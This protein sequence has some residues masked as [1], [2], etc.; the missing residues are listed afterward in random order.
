MTWSSRV[1]VE[2]QELSS[3]FESLVFKLESMSSQMKFHIFPMAC[4]CYEMAPTFSVGLNLET[5]M[6]LI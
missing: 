1:N 3:H 2:S 6:A 4:F 5:S